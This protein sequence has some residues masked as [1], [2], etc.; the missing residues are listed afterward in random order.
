MEILN[1]LV[2]VPALSFRINISLLSLVPSPHCI[3]PRQSHPLS[4]PAWLNSLSRPSSLISGEKLSTLIC[5]RW[6]SFLLDT[7]RTLWML[8]TWDNVFF[9]SYLAP[10]L[11]SSSLEMFGGFCTCPAEPSPAQSHTH[12][13]PC[14]PASKQTNKQM[15]LEVL[16]PASSHK[17]PWVGQTRKPVLR[18]Q[19]IFQS[20]GAVGA[21]ESCPDCTTKAW[22]FIYEMVSYHQTLLCHFLQ[23]MLH[24]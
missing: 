11:V 10:R 13:P 18:H 15:Q 5:F 16:S 7:S 12:L 20:L 24:K 6:N 9:H 19:P 17:G 1:P 8:R 3:S 2:L 23:D 4:I 21:A 22:A 14:K